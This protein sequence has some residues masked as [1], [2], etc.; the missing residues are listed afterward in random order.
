MDILAT[1]QAGDQRNILATV[2]ANPPQTKEACQAL[3]KQVTTADEREEL[4]YAIS[5]TSS[6][7]TMLVFQ[8]Y[9]ESSPMLTPLQTPETLA[10]P[11]ALVIEEEPQVINMTLTDDHITPEPAPAPAVEPEAKAKKSSG[12]KQLTIEKIETGE[13]LTLSPG[14]L[15]KEGNPT[16]IVW[17]KGAKDKIAH[18]NKDCNGYR[19]ISKL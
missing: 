19:F 8:A 3:F 12:R 4:F 9:S 7:D 18:Y 17:T 14:D 2:Q 1:L 13:Q 5:A 6:M 15:C 16:G 11:E 10:I